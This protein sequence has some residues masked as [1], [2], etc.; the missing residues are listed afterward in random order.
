MTLTDNCQEPTA[1][2]ISPSKCRTSGNQTEESDFS[3]PVGSDNKGGFAMLR[4]K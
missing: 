1:S 4:G 2:Q 3:K